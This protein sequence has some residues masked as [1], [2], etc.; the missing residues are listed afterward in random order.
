MFDFINEGTVVK[1]V[2]I[3]FL[4]EALKFVCGV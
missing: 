4:N 1:V 3:D 2:E